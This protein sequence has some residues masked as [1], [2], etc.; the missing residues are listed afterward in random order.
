LRRVTKYKFDIIIFILIAIISLTHYL[1]SSEN[2]PIHNF[3]RLLYIIPIILGGFRY[4]FKGAILISFVVSLIY[5]PHILLAVGFGPDTINELFDIVLFF[6]VGIIAGT[7]YEKK[8]AQNIQ[9]KEEL[10]KHMILEQYTNSIIESIKSG[11]VVINKDMFI[12][13]INQGAIDILGANH[14]CVDKNFMEVF[15]C[16]TD[17]KFEILNAINEGK[18]VENIEVQL[19]KKEINVNISIYPLNLKN[20]NKGLVIIIDDITE[21]KKLQIQAQRNEKLVALGELSSGIAHEIRNP[22]AIIKA[23]EQT[24]KSELKGNE[25][26]IK[27]LDII[28]EEVE[29][30]NKIVKGLMEFA[31]PSKSEVQLYYLNDVIGEVMLIINKYATQRYVSFEVLLADNVQI[32]ADKEQLKQAFIN[33]IFNAVEA[34]PKGGIIKIS[35]ILDNDKWV[36]L[37]FEDTGKGIEENNLQKIF[38][39]FFTTKEQGTGLGLSIVHR[40]LEEHGCVI[41]VIS[42]PDKGTKFEIMFPI[43]RE[44][45]EV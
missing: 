12:T 4:G 15:H 24:M 26:A 44:G 43:K 41:D 21:L 6:V 30:A 23:I 22:L 31:K 2:T 20:I 27:E 35:S 18:T 33:I 36:K 34:M 13:I 11:V 37:V 42:N 32:I 19:D 1:T 39:P 38:N 16:C 25:E 9:L 5:S 40:I 45:A 28:D 7:L 29:R 3:I 10:K 8:T 17:I 14:D